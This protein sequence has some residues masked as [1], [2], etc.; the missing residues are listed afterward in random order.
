MLLPGSA[1]SSRSE[2]VRPSEVAWWGDV[3]ALCPIWSVLG[4][5]AQVICFLPWSS[6]ANLGHTGCGKCPLDHEADLFCFG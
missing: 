4:S 3:W 6:L 5:S 1:G 2:S